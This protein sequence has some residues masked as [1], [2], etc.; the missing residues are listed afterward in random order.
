MEG[1]KFETND[2][3][4]KTTA[5]LETLEKLGRIKGEL[6]EQSRLIIN[7]LGYRENQGMDKIIDPD[8]IGVLSSS[9]RKIDESLTP[10]ELDFERFDSGLDGV[11]ASFDTMFKMENRQLRDN[12]EDL[13]YL[14]SH[15]DQF[16]LALSEIDKN[17]DEQAHP[18][19]SGR[20]RHCLGLIANRSDLLNKKIQIISQYQGR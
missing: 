1:F 7:N 9:M 2:D 15:L 11:M 12:P 8:M 14:R 10:T 18:Q 16:A 5:R 6:L 13:F 3:I 20:I 17:I 4:N 19:T